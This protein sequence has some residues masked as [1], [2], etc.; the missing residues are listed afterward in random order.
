AFQS[1]DQEIL[2]QLAGCAQTQLL[3]GSSGMQV[4]GKLD[5]R[6]LLLPIEQAKS[7]LSKMNQTTR[8]QVQINELKFQ[9]IQ[10]SENEKPLIFTVT[11]QNESYR[12][13]AQNDF[14]LF[15]THYQCGMIQGTFYSLNKRQQAV[16]LTWKQLM[17]RF[18]EPEVLFEKKE[19]SSLFKEIIPLLSEVGEVEVADEVKAEVTDIPV[20]FVFYFRKSKGK[21]QTRVD[22]VYDK[23]IFST[24]AK[25]EVSA[26]DSSEVLRDKAQEQRVLDLFK[27]YRY[28][29]NETGY[30]RALPSGEEL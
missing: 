2:S 11:K 18:T 29:K 3:L 27:M 21:I 24:D 8:L 12:L 30:E 4:K 23:V 26:G 22:F 19:L 6:F 7:L 28:R 17:R 20:E 15:L 9:G 10:F 14:D 16:Y 1:E 25:H 13:V 5:K